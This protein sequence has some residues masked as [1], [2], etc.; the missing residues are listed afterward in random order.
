MAPTIVQRGSDS[1]SS[2]GNPS[3]TITLPSPTTIGNILIG[4]WKD[5]DTASTLTL[6]PGWSQL[7]NSPYDAGTTRRLVM[8]FKAVAAT[9][10]NVVTFTCSNDSTNK[11]LSVVEVSGIDSPYS[12]VQTPSASSVTSRQLVTTGTL[13]KANNYIIA[14]C[15]QSSANGGSTSVD[16]G[17]T[18]RDTFSFL[19]VADKITA[20]TT[21]QAPTFSW[22]TARSSFG[23]QAVFP[24][25][26][27]APAPGTDIFVYD[28]STW[29]SH[30]IREL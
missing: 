27:A 8:A 11:A 30:T 29:V 6:P 3:I 15:E 2:A 4:V 5:N 16:S 22:L 12:A 18:V 20:A 24:E 9:N 10:E 14:A 23:M 19:I 26:S 1:H 17:F 7:G 28:G 21:A 13:A 25:K